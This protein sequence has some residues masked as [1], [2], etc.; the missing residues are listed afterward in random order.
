MKIRIVFSLFLIGA[1]NLLY[2]VPEEVYSI[3]HQE[4]LAVLARADKR[5]QNLNEQIQL[6]LA[7]RKANL[8]ANKAF[9]KEIGE[10]KQAVQED[11]IFRENLKKL[12]KEFL[13]FRD[14]LAKAVSDNYGP[15]SYSRTLRVHSILN[16]TD[17][18]ANHIEEMIFPENKQMGDNREDKVLDSGGLFSTS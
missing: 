14:Q 17:W 8:K 2:A 18:Y 10:W 4:E 12:Q 9:L 13:T 16:L 7:E 11:K 6:F 3:A 15:C 5:L 1:S